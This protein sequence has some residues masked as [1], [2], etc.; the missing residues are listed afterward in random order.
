[1]A[2]AMRV[3]GQPST[4]VASLV[5]SAACAQQQPKPDGNRIDGAE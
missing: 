3:P 4:P 2:I 1:M 5:R